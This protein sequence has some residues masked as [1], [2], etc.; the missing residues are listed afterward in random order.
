MHCCYKSHLFNSCNSAS[1]LNLTDS[2]RNWLLLASDLVSPATR[3][4]LAGSK[5]AQKAH[6]GPSVNHLVLCHCLNA[7]P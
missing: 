5:N 2:R 4:H 3:F 1:S 6:N 7:N